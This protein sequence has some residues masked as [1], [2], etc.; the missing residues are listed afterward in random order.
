M[1]VCP[2]IYCLGFTDDECHYKTLTFENHQI[3]YTINFCFSAD[4]RLVYLNK[5]IDS[6]RKQ[7]LSS[8]FF[9]N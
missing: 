3:D 5:C 2:D 9:I 8:G 7:Q 6:R 4:H 1:K